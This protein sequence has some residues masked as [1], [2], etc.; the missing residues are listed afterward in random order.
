[1]AIAATCDEGLHSVR[2]EDL[3]KGRHSVRVGNTGRV[4]VPLLHLAITRRG[5][6]PDARTLALRCPLACGGARSE[7]GVSVEDH[8]QSPTQ[9]HDRA[10]ATPGPK[11]RG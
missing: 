11:V 6:A 4:M 8:S 7:E 10:T 5:G 2:A 9:D 1:M 3:E